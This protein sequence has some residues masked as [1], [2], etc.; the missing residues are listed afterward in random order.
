MRSAT[1]KKTGKDKAY[2]EWIHT[3]P[4]AVSGMRLEQS[5]SADPSP[6]AGRTTAHHAGDHGASQKAPDRTAIPLCDAHHQHGPHAIHGPL[7]KNFWKFHGIDKEALI[8]SLNR[9]YDGGET[10]E[11]DQ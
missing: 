9:A 8:Q 11:E 3:Q 5:I 4:C 1:R 2:L 7:G 6:C 10:N